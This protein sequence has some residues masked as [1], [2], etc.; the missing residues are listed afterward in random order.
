MSL[1][2]RSGA[3]VIADRRGARVARIDVDELRVA[4]LLRLD[5]PLEPAGWASAE[6][7]PMI[8]MTSAFLMST[9]PFVIAPRPNVAAKLATVG[10]CQTLA[11]VSRYGLRRP[12]S[13]STGGS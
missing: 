13:P 2:A 10:P 6:F 1:P 4:D 7:P 12:R 8:K 11:C 5:R 9:Q 3:L